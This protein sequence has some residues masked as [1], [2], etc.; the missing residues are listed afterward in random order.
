M[1][2]ARKY[3]RKK[4]S[5]LG[6]IL[7]RS[8]KKLGIDLKITQQN[9]LDKW[10]EIVGEPIDSISKPQYFKFRTLFVNVSDP[11]WLQQLVFMED[12]IIKKINKSM[13]R[14]FIQKIY[15]KVGELS[16]NKTKKPNEKEDPRIDILDFIN[17]SDE[18]DA[19]A[20]LGTLKNADLK[21]TLKR[22]MIKT[23]GAETFRHAQ[24]EISP[25]HS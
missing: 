6:K 16:L 20:A 12:E 9:V 21:K 24:K 13:G 25:T 14:K 10:L 1:A 3:S 7:N 2:T 8:F 19:D 22:I 18:K 4:L 11:M 23:K 5:H 17:K 15:F